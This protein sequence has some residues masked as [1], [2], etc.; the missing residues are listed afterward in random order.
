MQGSGPWRGK[1]PP[2]AKGGLLQGWL[3]DPH[4]DPEA[5][6]QRPGALASRVAATSPDEHQDAIQFD[7][8]M[9][10]EVMTAQAFKERLQGAPPAAR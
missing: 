7:Y 8:P 3:L 4:R 5:C 1:G 10:S 6:V 9:F 2:E